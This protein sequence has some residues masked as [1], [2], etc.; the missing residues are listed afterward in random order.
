MTTAIWT[1]TELLSFKSYGI[2]PGALM[3]ASQQFKASRFSLLG[4]GRL[5]TPTPTG[6]LA[7]IHI[8]RT[9]SSIRF[10]SHCTIAQPVDTTHP[11]ATTAYS[12]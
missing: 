3:R 1:A 11:L 4:L 7:L 2:A 5:A 9:F 12:G 10:T 8:R 6:G